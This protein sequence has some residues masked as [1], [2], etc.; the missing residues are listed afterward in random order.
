MTVQS[1][2]HK[3]MDERMKEFGVDE[4]DWPDLNLTEHLWDES[5][6]RLRAF[7]SNTDTF[8]MCFW[9]NGQKF[10]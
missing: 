3:D 6:R 1:K 9:K 10:P 7:P 2:V 8:R 4:L 5:K